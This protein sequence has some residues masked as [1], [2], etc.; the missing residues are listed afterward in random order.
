[1]RIL[2][3]RHGESLYNLDQR[4]GGNPSLSDSGHKYGNKLGNFFKISDVSST[5]YTSTK[6]RV[7]ETVAYCTR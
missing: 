5:V 2:I 3:T 1:M 7:L 6:K 4:I